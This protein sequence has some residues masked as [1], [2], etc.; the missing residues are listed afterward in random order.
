[1]TYIKFK[2]LIVLII[3]SLPLSA[4]FSGLVIKVIDGDTIKIKGKKIKDA[5]LIPNSSVTDETVIYTIDDE[6]YLRIKAIEILGVVDDYLVVK[7]NI[8]EGMRVVASPLNSAI[9]G[10]ALTPILLDKNIDG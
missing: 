10:M 5:F 3:F 9:D 8:K 1:M 2:L 4:D 7:G 6:N